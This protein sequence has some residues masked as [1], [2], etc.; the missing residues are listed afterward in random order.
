MLMTGL[1]VF[2]GVA[3]IFAK[4]PRRTMLR[5]LKYDL[6]IDLLVTV[7]VLFLHWGSFEGVMAASIAGLLT[8]LATSG[9]K[10]LVGFV[11]GDSYYP[12]RIRLDV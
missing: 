8:S 3:L 9:L 4:L 2:T 10:R 5:A 11:D 12:G 7:L 6:A 1:T